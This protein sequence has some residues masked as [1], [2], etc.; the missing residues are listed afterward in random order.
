MPDGLGHLAAPK[1]DSGKATSAKS[2]PSC[3]DQDPIICKTWG[4]LCRVCGPEWQGM[5]GFWE[6]REEHRRCG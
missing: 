1:I 5:D 4:W 2:T 6:W 3:D